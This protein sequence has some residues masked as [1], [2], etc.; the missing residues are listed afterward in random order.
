MQTQQSIACIQEVP[1]I[2]KEM[3]PHKVDLENTVQNLFSEV[4][5]S[6]NGTGRESAVE[7]EAD[8]GLRK[9]KANILRCEHEMVAVDPDHLQIGELLAHIYNHLCQ[10]LVNYLV[11]LPVSVVSGTVFRQVNKVMHFWP[12]QRLI[13]QQKRLNLLESQ[14]HGIAFLLLENDASQFLLLVS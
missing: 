9:F 14:K 2:F 11:I 3:E 7:I 4:E 5:R 13:I 10:L 12:N 6:E 8:V 1:R